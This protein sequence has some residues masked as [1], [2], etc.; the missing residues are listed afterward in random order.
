M[1]FGR[2]AGKQIHRYKGKQIGV[3]IHGQ[4]FLNQPVKHRR[5]LHH[6]T[7]ANHDGDE[8]DGN[9]GALNPSHTALEHMGQ[10]LLPHKQEEQDNRQHLGIC[11][12]PAGP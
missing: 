6:S 5:L 12:L 8:H 10:E 9:Q 4:H 3:H 11:G 2:H 1:P 7:I